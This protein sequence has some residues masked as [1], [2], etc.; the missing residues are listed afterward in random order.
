MKLVV[1]KS[2]FVVVLVVVDVVL[3]QMVEYIGIY[4]P[5]GYSKKC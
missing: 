5:I 3:H 2:V 1:G 4:R